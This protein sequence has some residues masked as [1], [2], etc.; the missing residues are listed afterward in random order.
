MVFHNEKLTMQPTQKFIIDVVD[1]TSGRIA[2]RGRWYLKT[3]LQT[4]LYRGVTRCSAR[5]T[6]HSSRDRVGLSAERIRIDTDPYKLK[7]YIE[8][9]CMP[10]KCLKFLPARIV[11]KALG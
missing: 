5:V 3:T 4:G 1:Y 6:V 10:C 11:A 8:M 9:L 7:G 2:W